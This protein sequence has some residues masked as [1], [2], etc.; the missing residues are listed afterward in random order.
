MKN[1]LSTLALVFAAII[2]AAFSLV[3]ELNAY[4]E[5]QYQECFLAVKSNPAVVGLPQSSIE[6]FCDCALTAIVDEGRNDQDSAKQC[7]REKLNN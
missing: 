2:I 6:S 3:S 5:E 1:F 4:P 7:A